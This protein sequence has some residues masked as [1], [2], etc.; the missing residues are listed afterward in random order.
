MMFKHHLNELV[1]EVLQIMPDVLQPREREII[2]MRNYGKEESS[3]VGD[4]RYTY[5]RGMTLEEVGQHY[6]VTRERIRQIEAK[7]FE[8]VLNS[9]RGFKL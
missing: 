4:K 8:K 6:G 5:L 2:E 9:V 1:Y 3:G 7:A